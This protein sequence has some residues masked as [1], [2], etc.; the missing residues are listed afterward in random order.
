MKR[1]ITTEELDRSQRRASI[2]I[3]I[4]VPLWLIALAIWG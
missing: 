3:L 4:F 1:R 2:C